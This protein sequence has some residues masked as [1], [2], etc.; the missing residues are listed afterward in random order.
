MK[1]KKNL[2]PNQVQVLHNFNFEG[3]NKCKLCDSLQNDN[4]TNMKI[5]QKMKKLEVNGLHY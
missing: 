5:S 3:Q 2:K 1:L 4:D